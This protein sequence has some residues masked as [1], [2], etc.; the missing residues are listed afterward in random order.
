MTADLWGEDARGIW[1]SQE[2]VV[3][4]MSADDMR[5]RADRWN[6]EFEGTNW[7]AF[8]CAG[9]LLLFFASM[10]VDRR[11][12]APADRRDDRHRRGRSIWSFVGL[13]VASGRWLDEGATCIRAYKVQLRAP[14]AGRHGLGAD[15]PAVDD[16]MRAPDRPGK[17]GV[18][19]AARPPAS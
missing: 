5:A 3:T 2:S 7:I 11:D 17:L 16:G 1:Q 13:R 19:G 15:H 12:D 9:V 4:R 6:R 14:A 10:L 8:V 18:V